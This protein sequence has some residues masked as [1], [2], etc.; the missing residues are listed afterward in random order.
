VPLTILSALQTERGQHIGLR[1][2]LISLGVALVAS[3]LSEW[4]YQR[5]RR[6]AL[7]AGARGV[8]A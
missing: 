7:P 2:C 8:A 3:L 5:W 1:L 6:Q 4:S